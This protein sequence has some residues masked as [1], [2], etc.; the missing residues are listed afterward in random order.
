MEWISLREYARRYKMNQETVKHLIHIGELEA[1]KTAGG[2]YKIK[3]N[4]DTVSRTDYEKEKEKRI[5]AET[6]L[7]NIL[8]I[9]GVIN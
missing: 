7:Q 6:K 5:Q 2:H 1:R 8:N 4:G 3:I 9:I